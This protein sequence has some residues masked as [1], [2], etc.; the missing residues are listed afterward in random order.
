[1]IIFR[2]IE[3][4][5]QIGATIFIVLL[6][7]VSVGGKTLENYLMSFVQF[8]ETMAPVREVAESGA[9]LI[10]PESRMKYQMPFPPPKKHFQQNKKRALAS[11]PEPP[12][13]PPPSQLSAPAPADSAVL[14]KGHPLQGVINSVFNFIF[15]TNMFQLTK[16]LKNFSADKQASKPPS[17]SS[18]EKE[19]A[20][21]AESSK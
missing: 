8:S 19:Q 1:M 10:S 14:P 7:Q 17:P 6:L 13:V 2:M 3:F 5:F 15:K 18:P 20:P 11:R 12:A 21:P 9:K 16:N 4:M